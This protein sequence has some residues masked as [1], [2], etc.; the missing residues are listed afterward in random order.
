MSSHSMDTARRGFEAWQR[1][2]FETIEAILD[3]HVQ[4]RWFEPG[5]WDCQSR[6]DVMRTLRER[7]EQGFGGSQLE[8]VE[9]GDDAVIVVAHPRAVAGDDWPEEAAT[10]ITLRHDK[11]VEMQDYPTREEALAAVST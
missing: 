11:V 5:D 4:W 2:D 3:A 6:E 8:F 10:I 1:G 7:Y 9:T